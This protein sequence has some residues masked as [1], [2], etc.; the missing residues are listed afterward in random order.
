MASH[1][2][3]RGG[4]RVRDR[5][6]KLVL[7]EG[8]ARKGVRCVASPATASRPEG[9]VAQCRWGQALPLALPVARTL[10]HQHPG[11][12]R[13]PH[14]AVAHLHTIPRLCLIT[15]C[16]QCPTHALTAPWMNPAGFGVVVGG[17]PPRYALMGALDFPSSRTP[18]S[19]VLLGQ[20]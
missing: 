5:L 19:P 8:E 14:R 16:K 10:L 18:P 17:K 20:K 7:V 2:Q 3:P 15:R 12:R 6:L 13:C 4:S 1:V 11:P 9:E